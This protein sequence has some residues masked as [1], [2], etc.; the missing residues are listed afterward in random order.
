[1]K[2]YLEHVAKNVYAFLVWDQSW[3]S[4][5]NCYLLLEHNNITL[6]DSG[7]EEHSHFLFSALK[8]KGISKSDITH[9]I[10]THGHKDHIGA[11]QY[12]S[13]IEG[14]IHN[15]D[16]ELIP[17]NSRNKLKRKLP[18]NGPTGND[19]E[20]VLLGHHTK[21]SVLLYHRGSKVLFCGDHIC[22][23][24]EQLSGDVVDTGVEE[25]G[26]YKRFV[27]EWSR[28]EEMREQHNFN[29][30]IVGLKKIANYDVEYLCTGHGV[31][32]KGK[33]K[34]FIS[35]LLEFE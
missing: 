22:F 10:A 26:K 11:I 34:E 12:L 25:R 35:D 2:T 30:F 1:M 21:G 33:V 24:G 9:F 27:S 8:K 20:C 5:N 14:Y 4:Y 28:N 18:D 19:L 23:F 13:D 32:L 6:I 3:N 16:L 7:K 29:L 15:Q 31:V 17:E